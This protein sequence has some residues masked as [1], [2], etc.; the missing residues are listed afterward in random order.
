MTNIFKTIKPPIYKKQYFVSSTFDKSSGDKV[1]KNEQ[2]KP[3]SVPTM[4]TYHH[5]SQIKR[6]MI[7]L[8]KCGD[9]VKSEEDEVRFMNTFNDF[10]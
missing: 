1:N 3:F 5:G 10:E 7:R 8:P 4:K 9:H 2:S 6:R